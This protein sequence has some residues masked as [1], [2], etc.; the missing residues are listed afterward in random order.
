MANEKSRDHIEKEQELRAQ[1]YT[2]DSLRSTIRQTEQQIAQ[3]T[4]N[5][6]QELQNERVQ[7]EGEYRKLQ[8]ENQ[9]QAHHHEL[10]ELKSPQDGIVKDIATHTPGTV[11][12]PGTV[13]MTVVPKNDPIEAEVWITH[14]DAGFVQPQQHAQVKLA[15]YPFQKYGMVNGEVSQVSP[16][17]TEPDKGQRDEPGYRAVIRL[18]SAFMENAGKRYRLTPGMQVTAEINLGNRSVLEYLLSPVQ[19]AVF[20]AGHER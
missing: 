10:L 6:R 14:L 7:A 12:S 3:I 17:A 15:A 8:Q 4:S 9:K 16:D 5:Y 20:E 1:S 18:P 13:V 11:V 19:K 2:V